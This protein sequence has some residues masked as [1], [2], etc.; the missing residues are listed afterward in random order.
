MGTLNFNIETSGFLVLGATREEMG[1]AFISASNVFQ[2]LRMWKPNVGEGIF[3]STLIATDASRNRV[4]P[5][6]VATHF[7]A[8]LGK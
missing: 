3:V 6:V 8:L 4:K 1:G 2:G 7:E 5:G